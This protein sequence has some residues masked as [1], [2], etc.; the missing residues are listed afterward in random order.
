M[1]TTDLF[2]NDPALSTVFHGATHE[3]TNCPESIFAWWLPILI[4]LGIYTANGLGL[5][6]RWGTTLWMDR[7]TNDE[8]NPFENYKETRYANIFGGLQSGYQQDLDKD[9]DIDFDNSYSRVKAGNMTIEAGEEKRAQLMDD[10]NWSMLPTEL[11]TI[12]FLIDDEK[13]TTNK[14]AE[15]M[16]S[17]SLGATCRDASSS[18]Y[19]QSN[20]N[21]VAV[22]DAETPNASYG[23]C[24]SGKLSKMNLKVRIYCEKWVSVSYPKGRFMVRIDSLSTRRT[25]IHPNIFH[26]ASIFAMFSHQYCLALSC[27]HILKVLN[28]QKIFKNRNFRKLTRLFRFCM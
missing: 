11:K 23:S 3:H 15:A 6:F 1:S 4:T 24:L 9:F 5:A 26:L 16:H 19:D 14:S 21:I 28:N 10:Y 2:P 18:S 13:A 25:L 12:P 27:L 20:E 22:L 8:M 17:L 7:K